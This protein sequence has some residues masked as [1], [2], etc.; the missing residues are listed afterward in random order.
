MPY[1]PGGSA[2]IAARLI[3]DEWAKALGGSIFI[4]NSAGA[5][6]NIGVDWVAKAPPD[7]YTVGLQTVSLAITIPPSRSRCPTT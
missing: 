1:A 3:A 5:G 2:D 4:E 7:G 6:G